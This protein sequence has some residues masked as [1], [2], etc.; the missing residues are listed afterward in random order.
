MNTN[1][2][3]LAY[4][5]IA[6]LNLFFTGPAQAEALGNEFEEISRVIASYEELGRFNGAI[7]IKKGNKIIY[8]R[9]N[10]FANTTTRTTNDSDKIFAIGSLS[11]QFT[12]SAILL[13]AQQGKLS[14]DDNIAKHLP[15]YQNEVGQKATIYH[16]LTHTAGIPDPMDTGKGIDGENDHLMKE[17]T[18]AIEKQ[19]LISTFKDLPN[20][21]APGSRYEYTNTGYILLADIIERTSGKSYA[22]FLQVNLFGP[23]G[24][25]NTSAKRPQK[26]SLLVESYNGIGSDKI[27]TT[28]IHNSWLVGAAGLYST[29]L[30]LFKWVDSM[31]NYKIFKDAKFDY[32]LIN[33]VDLGQNDEFYGYGM[34]LKKLWGQKVYR[35]DGATAGTIADFI[36][37][38]TQDITI[39]IYMNHT[40]NVSNIDLSINIRKQIIHQ[41][42]GILLAH[43]AP[44]YLTLESN[45]KFPVEHYS[46]H[47]VFDADHQVEITLD[48]NDLQLKTTGK[49]NWSLYNLAQG[50]HLPP[51][52]FTQKSTNLFRLLNTNKLEGLADLFDEKMASAPLNVF[53][54]FW[55]QLES[56][57]GVLED[58][59]SF[60]KSSDNSQIQQRL[61]F[62]EGI[63]DMTVFFNNEG[64]IGGIRNSSPVSKDNNSFTTKLLTLKDDQLLVDGYLIKQREDLIFKFTRDGENQITGFSYNQMGEH[65]AVKQ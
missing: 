21:F 38:P 42:S 55:Q 57:L 24:M 26:S 34:E 37:I 25:L 58:N 13:L 27:H 3:I 64:K 52:V 4:M 1:K 18:L 59:Y 32:L 14:L 31:N 22:D 51:D 16:L 2:K 63:V 6:M 50:T 8:Q 56:E 33:P 12:A 15:Y 61:I 30:D 41:I 40:H 35:H 20:L 53:E 5:T 45:K 7:A 23:A 36:Y 9:A 19:L 62:K 65:V 10:G 46:G 11:K 48:N 39:V 44:V 29:T 43:D 60:S 28:K 47:Y 49:H 17:K 54:G